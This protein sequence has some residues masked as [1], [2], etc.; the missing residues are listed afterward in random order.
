MYFKRTHVLKNIYL[1][2][3]VRKNRKRWEFINP[4]KNKLWMSISQFYDW[5]GVG[6]G[7]I[8]GVIKELKL[9]HWDQRV[10]TQN[11]CDKICRIHLNLFLKITKNEL[12]AFMKDYLQKVYRDSYH[13]KLFYLVLWSLLSLIQLKAYSYW[14]LFIL[15]ITCCN[16]SCLRLVSPWIS[17]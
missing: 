6:G 14:S 1:I 9:L 2:R 12:K 16:V 11:S 10:E 15:N 4:Y 8:Q 5:L 13:Y 7:L 3:V 17:W